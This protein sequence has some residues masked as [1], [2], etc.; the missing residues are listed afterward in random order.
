MVAQSGESLETSPAR[1][2][3]FGGKL[4]QSLWRLDFVLMALNASAA[5]NWRV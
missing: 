1:L 3:E 4:F 2:Q 5:P